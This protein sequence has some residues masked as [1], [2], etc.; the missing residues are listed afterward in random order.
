MI[1]DTVAPSSGS[2]LGN[3]SLFQR[4]T[5]ENT[6]NRAPLL[7]HG[8]TDAPLGGTGD[9]AA[10]PINGVDDKDPLTG[11]AFIVVVGFL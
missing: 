4:R 5:F 8:N 9:K 11:E 10:R 2:H 7:N 1:S 3:D 6:G